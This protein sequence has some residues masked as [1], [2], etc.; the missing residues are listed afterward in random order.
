MNEPRTYKLDEIYPGTSPF[1]QG[2][3]DR[4]F[5]RTAEVSDLANLISTY[6]VVSLYGNSGT[7]KSSLIHAGVAP[8]LGESRCLVVRI[9]GLEPDI[10]QSEIKNIFAFHLLAAMTPV[11]K[12]AD[13]KSDTLSKTLPSLLEELPKR[14]GKATEPG[15]NL[16]P[17]RFLFID[18]F[19]EILTRHPDRWK[20]RAGF[21]EQLRDALEAA[22]RLHLVLAAREEYLAPLERLHA[23][24]SG[25]SRSRY[26]LERL[27][28]TQAKD[29]ILKPAR[30]AGYT[31][32]EKMVG[33]VV[34][35][36]LKSKME[37]GGKPVEISGE[38]VEPLH[39]Q[40][41]CL[42]MAQSKFKPDYS[43]G[44]ISG[45]V[46]AALVRYYDRAVKKVAGPVP[47]R[48]ARLRWF[49]S[50]NLLTSARTRG[51]VHLSKAKGRLG[52]VSPEMLKALEGVKILRE[53]QRAG[54]SWYELTHDRFIDPILQSN[55]AFFEG[56]KQIGALL[57]LLLLAAGAVLGYR[58]LQKRVDTAQHTTNVLNAAVESGPEQAI[59]TE[60]ALWKNGAQDDAMR[61]LEVGREKAPLQSIETIDRQL[62]QAEIEGDTAS[63]AVLKKAHE[64]FLRYPIIRQEMEAQPKLR[65]YICQ[66]HFIVEGMSGGKAL[67]E[68]GLA[69]A[70][71]SYPNAEI[72]PPAPGASN[73][74]YVLAY[75]GFLTCTDAQA[76]SLKLFH[77]SNLK[78]TITYWWNCSNTCK[79]P[80]YDHPVPAGVIRMPDAHVGEPYFA[81]IPALPAGPF[82]LQSGAPPEGIA[83]RAD[84]AIYGVPAQAGTAPFTFQVSQS[85]A[86][87]KIAIQVQ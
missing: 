44:G 10:P 37:T 8:K 54:A 41:M 61:L 39:L 18:Q 43:P 81:F 11:E 85:G 49:I 31:P 83:V 62:A 77:D 51:L 69:A 86:L 20:D 28:V 66:R 38:F 46:N 40:I 14:A 21:F 50:R 52:G 74:S 16:G 68:R 36:L 34:D 59:P 42:E 13:V 2:W 67:V 15:K 73:P 71:K 45:D 3:S 17:D 78:P 12:H 60:L 25:V 76:L 23:V 5:G 1:S 87:L 6:R 80:N 35:D 27:T 79:D 19:E 75:D 56:W 7:G 24:L 32:D 58:I 53:E 72:F 30:L 47:F 64:E 84:G 4:F 22:P 63:I 55:A 33:K 70:R 57:V 65:E 26:H 82:T 9:S 48:E 29:A